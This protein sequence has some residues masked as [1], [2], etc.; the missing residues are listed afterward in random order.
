MQGFFVFH[1]K[2]Q[3][4]IHLCFVTHNWQTEA[5][6]VLV[7][8]YASTGNMQVLGILFKRHSL[9]CFTVC[10]KYL[11]DEMAA[12]DAVMQVFEKLI[13]DL[14]KHEVQN[15]RSW[16]HSVCR[17]HCLMELRKPQL[18]TA[19]QTEEDN[20]EERFMESALL[21]HPTEDKQILEEKLQTMEQVLT[22]LNAAQASCLRLFYLE[23]KSYE[24]ITKQLGLTLNEVKSHIQNGKRNLKIG[25]VRKGITYASILFLWMQQSA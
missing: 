21:L 7:K 16:L 3:K 25:M 24:D 23:G 18:L 13:N 22:E 17:N 10:M 14:R 20:N 9:L 4:K 8:H 15:F 1:K 19:L 12:E 5:D 2:P 6:E 11:K